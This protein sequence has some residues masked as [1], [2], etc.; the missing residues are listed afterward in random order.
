MIYFTCTMASLAD[1]M[2]V[3]IFEVAHDICSGK[4]LFRTETAEVLALVK[5]ILHPL[6]I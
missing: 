4:A 3:D 1:D 2:R 5:S 6:D